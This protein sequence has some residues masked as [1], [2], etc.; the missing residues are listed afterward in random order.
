MEGNGRG[1]SYLKLRPKNLFYLEIAMNELLSLMDKVE[2]SGTFSVGGALPSTPLGLKVKGVGT[3]ALPVL[4]QQAQALINFSQQAPF[5]RGEETIVDTNVRNAWQIAAEDFELTNPQWEQDLQEAIDEIGKQLGL[6]GCNIEFEQYK[7]LIYE[8]GSFFTAHRDTEKI[9]N[10]FATLVVNLPSEHEGGDLIVSHGGQSQRYSFADKDNFHPNF[11]AFYADCYHEVKP[12]TSGY[13]VCLI[14]NLAIA[15]RKKQP[16]LSQQTKTIE[17]I[18]SVIQKWSQENRENPILAYLLE[19]S[20]SKQNIRLSNLKQGDFAKASVLLNA[21]EQNGCQAFLCLV[22]YYRTSYGETIYYGRYSPSYDLD[23]D[24]FEEYDI[25]EEEVYAHAFITAKGVKIDVEKLRL[26]EDKLLAETPLREGPGRGYSI[27]E[28]TGNEG[29][30]K[31]LWYER[32]A[33]IIWPKDREFDLVTRMDLNYGIHVLK[34][35][36]QEQNLAAGN[37]RQKIVQLA[38]H[39]LENLPSYRKNDI[40]KELILI[41]DIGLLKTF[42]HNQMNQQI[43]SQ[44]NAQVFIQIMERFGWESFEEDIRPYLTPRR[45][46]LYWLNSLVLATETLS[47]EGQSVMKRWVNDLW[48]PSLVYNLTEEEVENLVQIVS[49]L[50]IEALPDEITTFLS[51]QNQKDFLTGT[52]GPAL[53]NSLKQLKGRDY[54]HSIMNT[55]IENIRHRIAAEFPAPPDV[56]K[57]W[58]REGQ[59]DCDCEFCT[60]VN[61]FLPDPERRAISFY[62][63][64]KRNLLHIEARVEESQVEIDVEIRRRSPKFDGTCRKNQRRYDHKRELFDTAQKIV[65]EL[66]D[67]QI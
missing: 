34:R 51:G 41:A 7:L 43:L 50:K 12:I 14:Y 67:F 29:A 54:D 52:Y 9:P 25:D 33:V 27:S 53:V 6:D 21:A 56:P 11:I 4:E 31:E 8:E 36:L 30:T 38:D 61:Q 2:T 23:E 28:A 64:L 66:G 63:T 16:L 24:D 10:M 18:G 55:F 35:S 42:L 19:H 13:R 40:S 22:T 44:V 17:D 65:I 3:V 1:R 15:D 58:A 49:L 39:I 45:G 47:A 5:G 62:K 20:Y 57:N 26:D 37:Y 48:K 60:E 32:G 59:L 46:A